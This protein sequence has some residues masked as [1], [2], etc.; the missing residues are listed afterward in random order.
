[1]LWS[2]RFLRVMGG[3]GGSSRTEVPLNPVQIRSSM[4]SSVQIDDDC[5]AKRNGR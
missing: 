3:G 1:M 4:T 5:S 2:V